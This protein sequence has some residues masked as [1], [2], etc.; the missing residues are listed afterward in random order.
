MRGLAVSV[1]LDIADPA[2]FELAVGHHAGHMHAPAILLNWDLTSGARLDI[3]VVLNESLI[4][5]N[6]ASSLQ[7]FRPHLKGLT[8]LRGGGPLPAGTFVI[9]RLAVTTEHKAT[10]A[11]DLWTLYSPSLLGQ[12]ALTTPPVRTQNPAHLDNALLSPKLLIL[13]IQVLSRGVLSHEAEVVYLRNLRARA[14]GGTADG[15]TL[16]AGVLDELPVLQLVSAILD[17]AL[18]AETV[19]VL[20]RKHKHRLRD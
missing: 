20:T 16:S 5:L 3:G 11:S 8:L 9:R 18:L 14:V 7:V 4:S 2:P 13:C 10:S 6:P 19:T 17:E 1:P 15:V 12:E